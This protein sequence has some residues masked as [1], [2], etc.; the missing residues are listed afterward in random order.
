MDRL[1]K[2]LACVAIALTVVACGGSKT[3]S[4]SAPK[5]VDPTVPTPTPVVT[6]PTPQDPRIPNLSRAAKLTLTDLVNYTGLQ[7]IAFPE[8]LNTSALVG[9]PKI[10]L[11]LP[12]GRSA[13]FRKSTL[14]LAVEDSYGLWWMK[15]SLFPGTGT[16]TA[17]SFDA[18]YADDYMVSRV[19]AAVSGDDVA[20]TIYYRIRQTGENEC[21]P[22][23]FCNAF[24]QCSAPQYDSAVCYAYMDTN[25]TFSVKS[26]GTFN[27]KYS[28]WA[29][30]PEGQ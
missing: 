16:R 13:T 21:K 24:G 4:S 18:I 11:E 8:I 1:I 22:I 2:W 5:P 17:T 14:L 7:E 29:T 6:V 19:R 3:E 30:L 26:L 25:N 9:D 23:Q 27:T 12:A 15:Q 10:L 20:G 28:Q